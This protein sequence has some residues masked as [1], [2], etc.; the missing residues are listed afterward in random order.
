MTGRS[1][2]LKPSLFAVFCIALSAFTLWPVI[3]EDRAW[4][5]SIRSYLESDG[6][7]DSGASNLVSAIYLGYRAYDTLGETIVLLV[8]VSGAIAMIA[9]SNGMLARGYTEASQRPGLSSPGEQPRVTRK[10]RTELLDVVT[11]KLGPIVLIFGLYVMLF[12]HVSPGGGFQG[13]DRKSVV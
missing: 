8:A 4:P 9:A 10:N 3:K 1:S 13:G 7:A 11:S 2:A 12:G 5:D 6:F